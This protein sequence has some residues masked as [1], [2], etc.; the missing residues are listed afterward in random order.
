MRL[1]VFWVDGEFDRPQASAFA[2]TMMD[3]VAR[4]LRASPFNPFTI[5]TSSGDTFRVPNP[6][7]A[8]LNPRGTCVIV[9]DDSNCHSTLTALH[10]VSIKED[11]IAE[12]GADQPQI[13]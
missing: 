2:F 7:Y 1:P 3:L 5:T 9:F 6:D 4:L 8:H 13:G 11:P 12:S 10:I